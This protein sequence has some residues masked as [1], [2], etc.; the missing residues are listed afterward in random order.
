MTKKAVGGAVRGAY[1][2]VYKKLKTQGDRVLVRGKTD[3]GM[4][5]EMWVN[6]ATKTIETAY[7]IFK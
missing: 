3:G 4:I 1:K 7:P 6:T 5:V 2:N